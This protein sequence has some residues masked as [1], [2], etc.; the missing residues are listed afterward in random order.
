MPLCDDFFCC[1][2]LDLNWINRFL[3]EHF[4]SLRE[5]VLKGFCF[6]FA[7]DHFRKAAGEKSMQKGAAM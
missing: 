5:F 2:H 1:S 7:L 4:V 3:D 6:V